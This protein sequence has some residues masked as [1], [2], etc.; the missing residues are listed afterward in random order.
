MTEQRS[1]C[2]LH[3]II[4]LTRASRDGRCK[5]E[6]FLLTS[7]RAD[8]MSQCCSIY[9]F[10]SIC[11]HFNLS[12]FEW[13]SVKMRLQCEI[14]PP[15]SEPGLGFGSASYSL[16]GGNKQPPNLPCL[17]CGLGDKQLVSTQLA[18][19][20]PSWEINVYPPTHTHNSTLTIEHTFNNK[21]L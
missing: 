7:T 13:E 11:L 20:A 12:L 15:H 14:F 9:R 10:I 3:S 1:L 4:T 6:P 8:V 16:L 17:V 21:W 18:P 5:W 2:R 19:A